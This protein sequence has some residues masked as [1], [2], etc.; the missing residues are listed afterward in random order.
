[1]AIENH[2][3][4]YYAASA[5]DSKSRPSL[6]EDMSVDVCIV[7]AGFTGL[8]SALHLAERGYSVLVL[9]AHRIGWG[10]TGRNGGQMNTGQRKGAADLI[11]AFGETDAKRFWDLSEEARSLVRD[12]IEQ[13]NISCDLAWGNY[14]V[15][16]K[17][18]H[19]PDLQEEV[20]LRRDVFGYEQS[21]FLS[22]ETMAD[23]LSDTRCF[24]AIHDPD[25]NHLHPLN[26]A[27]GLADAAEESGALLF[28]SSPVV[29]VRET[30]D[31]PV[32]TTPTSTVKARHAVL[33]T[34][35][36]T[37]DVAPS[38]ASRIFPI[39]NFVIAT[40]PLGEDRARSLIRNLSAVHNTKFV[41]D[42]YRITA[43]FRMLFGGGEA[44]SPNDP[45]DI[46]AF[47]RPYMLDGFP[48]LKDARIDYAWGGRLAITHNRLPYFKRS[49]GG[50]YAMCGFSGH[51]LAMT[52]L[53]GKL[54][55]EAIAG[56]AERFDLFAKIQHVPF[57]GG[58]ALRYPIQVLGMMYYALRD[59]L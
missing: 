20:D 36:Y 54:A 41:L 23:R 35:A 30:T 56:D 43:D 37:G 11:S 48:S 29:N 24:G 42:Y 18:S 1:M 27:L 2:A 22:K 55:A 49:A 7:G 16:S 9:E 47:V 46:A 26:Y 19:T 14:T 38:F 44:Y 39:S 52:S 21:E 34:N 3:P 13:H 31:G 8:S 17:P 4:S 53:A 59:K 15:A 6:S 32:V 50:L 57:P 28:E 25:G 12:R 45:A 33:A 51:G 10:A 58:R 5:N 40:E